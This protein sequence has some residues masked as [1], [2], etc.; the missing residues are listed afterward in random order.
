MNKHLRECHN[1]NGTATIK[2]RIPPPAPSG[3][4]GNCETKRVTRVTEQL[5]RV[6]EF[7]FCTEQPFWILF[8]EVVLFY[9]FYAEITIFFTRDVRFGSYL[10][11]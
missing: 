11:R 1:K 7:S 8:L 4:A 9:Q 6:T 10:R 2:D 3:R 5:S